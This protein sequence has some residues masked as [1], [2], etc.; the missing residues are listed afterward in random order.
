LGQELSGSSFTHFGWALTPFPKTIPKDGS[1]IW[2]WIDGVPIGHPNYNLYRP[3]IAALFPGYN[4]S[5][6]AVGAFQIDLTSYNDGIHILQWSITDDQGAVDGLSRYF[7]IMNLTGGTASKPLHPSVSMREDPTGRL[8]LTAQLQER[9]YENRLTA[10]NR[11]SSSQ[12]QQTSGDSQSPLIIEIEELER[13]VIDLSTDI[14]S[15]FIGW[16]N[17]ENTGLP[18]GSTLDSDKGM[19]FWS[20]GPGFLGKHILHFSATDG[21]SKSKPVIVVV[22]IVP[23]K[24]VR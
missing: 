20:P 2:V 19:F 22:N 3:D 18:I 23:R 7:E 14:G 9:G 12:S 24:Y 10:R 6:G 5:N 15:S 16:G 21:V 1:T 17:S 11:K 13:I 4:N 8:R